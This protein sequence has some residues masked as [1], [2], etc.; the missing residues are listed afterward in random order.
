MPDMI[1]FLSI[2][3]IFIGSFI[4]AFIGTVLYLI[5]FRKLMR[6]VKTK[7]PSRWKK[8]AEIAFSMILTLSIRKNFR[9]MSDFLK[10]IDKI[11]DKDI[12]RLKENSERS[13]LVSIISFTIF[14]I[15]FLLIFILYFSQLN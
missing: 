13:F 9:I 12:I 3:S 1:L 10:E 4:T 2:F 8:M 5:Y 7:Y 6:Q 11:K 15:S 14:F